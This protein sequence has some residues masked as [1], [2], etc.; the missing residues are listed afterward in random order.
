MS[1]ETKKD[2]QNRLDKVKNLVRQLYDHHTD[3]QLRFNCD[4]AEETLD[5]LVVECDAQEAVAEIELRVCVRNVKLPIV[6]D[7][8]D[9]DSYAVTVLDPH[10]FELDSEVVDL[11]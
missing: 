4:G 2:L 9:V 8:Y 10:G 1:R 7:P 5:E 6:N 11:F 3:G